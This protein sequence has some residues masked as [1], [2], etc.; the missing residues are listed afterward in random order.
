L[1][2]FSL[3]IPFL[4][5]PPA[6]AAAGRSLLAAGTTG[7]VLRSVVVPVPTRRWFSSA[8]GL[9]GSSHHQPR[10]APRTT[11]APPSPPRLA[12]RRSAPSTPAP[13]DRVTSIASPT[14]GS[15]AAFTKSLDPLSRQ[16]LPC[17]S[18]PSTRSGVNPFSTLPRPRHALDAATSRF[19]YSAQF[20]ASACLH[21]SAQCSSRPV[22]QAQ[23]SS[24]PRFQPSCFVRA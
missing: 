12:G 19:H 2:L 4:A 17:R 16:R 5:S 1:Y 6:C 10:S 18:T 9:P 24:R 14:A 13:L 23:N 3:L 7:K 8:S 20:D 22:R 21:F 15:A 11:A